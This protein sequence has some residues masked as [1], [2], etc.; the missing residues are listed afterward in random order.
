MSRRIALVSLALVLAAL[1]AGC[2]AALMAG[3]RLVTPDTTTVP[4]QF[5]IGATP[6][7]IIPFRDQGK[8]YYQSGDGIDLAQAVS[9]ELITRKAASVVRSD[10]GVRTAFTDRN[11]EEVGWSEVAK[12][13]GAT[14]VLT[15]DIQILR[16]KDPGVIGM[17]R[18]Y[19]LVN[20]RV[21]DASKNCI[22]YSAQSIE[23]WVP[24]Y[25]AGVAESDVNPERLRY[26]LIASTAMH[27]VQKFYTWE[28][29]IG[30]E[31]RR[32]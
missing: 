5:T 11:L 2:S 30:P 28:R 26:A 4:A 15:G 7:V 20:V 27:V 31:P 22:V 9:G 14:L 25:G 19:S 3:S 10:E 12:A 18:G 24:E 23:T 21:Y 16:L 6:V 29:K 8:S 13:A 32:Y 17:L 1:A